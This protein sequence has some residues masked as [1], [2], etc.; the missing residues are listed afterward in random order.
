MFLLVSPPAFPVPHPSQEASRRNNAWLPPPWAILAMV[1]LGWNEFMAVLRWGGTS[2]WLCSGGVE[3]VH[4]FLPQ[5]HST[6][7][8]PSHYIPPPVFP[9]LLAASP[10][11]LS[12]FLPASLPQEPRAAATGSVSLL[13]RAG[14]HVAA[15]PGGHVRQR[16]REPP[17]IAH[18]LQIVSFLFLSI[19]PL[20]LVALTA[21][22]EVMPQRL[23]ML[24][25]DLRCCR[26]LMARAGPIIISVLR[27]LGEQAEAALS[28]H[29]APVPGPLRPNWRSEGGEDGGDVAM[30]DFSA[31]SSGEGGLRQRGSRREGEGRAAVRACAGA[32]VSVC[33]CVCVHV[34]VCACV[35]A[36]VRVC[37]CVCVQWTSKTR[38]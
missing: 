21:G 32:R 29:N 15:G 13:H 20:A 25:C 35:C 18:L 24:Q 1:V 31:G 12:L 36:C 23:L 6:C 7:P 38:D 26:A 9:S 34:C 28:A 4:G 8:P 11:T 14:G 5:H 3:R 37:V 27:R 22:R 17:T 19:L 30:R 10:C 33:V 16:P 2:S